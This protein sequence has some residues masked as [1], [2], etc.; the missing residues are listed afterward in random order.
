MEWSAQSRHHCRRL[1]VGVRLSESEGSAF[2][3]PT[4]IRNVLIGRAMGLIALVLTF[5]FLRGAQWSML[6]LLL[7]V[8]RNIY[9]GVKS[10][11]SAQTKK[12]DSASH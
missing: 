9:V 10:I 11:R 7:S 3:G 4:E 2:W 5:C 1:G 6:L 12:P 8:I